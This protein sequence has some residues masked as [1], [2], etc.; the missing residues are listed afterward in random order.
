[1]LP[2]L[3][4]F[5]VII[6]GFFVAREIFPSFYQNLLILYINFFTFDNQSLA[7]C[8]DYSGTK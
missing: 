4:G 8:N 1:M 2:G 5:L 3:S 6:H 7:R